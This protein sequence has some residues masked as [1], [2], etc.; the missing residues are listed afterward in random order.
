MTR[1]F[2]ILLAFTTFFASP[3]LAAAAGHFEQLSA[4]AKAFILKAA[5][6]VNT[7]KPLDASGPFG[8]MARA[9]SEGMAILDRELRLAPAG[10]AA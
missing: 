10:S 2:A 7:K 6:A 9:W 5:R 3:A 8:E 1:A 4:T